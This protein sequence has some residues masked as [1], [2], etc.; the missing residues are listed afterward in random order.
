[1]NNVVVA[2]T[3]RKYITYIFHNRFR[4][5]VKIFSP[6]N[7]QKVITFTNNI[8]W[9]GFFLDE[10]IIELNRGISN[11]EFLYFFFGSFNIEISLY[12]ID[13]WETPR[14]VLAICFLLTTENDHQNLPL[15]ISSS[16]AYRT[17]HI[18][19]HDCIYQ[20]ATC[21]LTPLFCSYLR[22]SNN[23]QSWSFPC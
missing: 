7:R 10:N 12:N 11:I 2:S 8:F 20:S 6:T 13:T 1:M 21:Y 22:T 5:Y 18:H 15:F 16:Y 23:F 3:L 14:I 19:I 17:S 4:G 9:D